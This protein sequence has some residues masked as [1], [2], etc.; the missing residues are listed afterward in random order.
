[1][2]GR[3]PSV[4]RASVLERLERLPY[5]ITLKPKG[6]GSVLASGQGVSTARPVLLRKP[7]LRENPPGGAGS[8]DAMSRLLLHEVLNFQ[9]LGLAGELD[10]EVRQ[11]GHQVLGLRLELLTR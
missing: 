3:P 6:E 4:P 5:R 2:P 11:D 10:T 1:M 9:H 8:H 7:W